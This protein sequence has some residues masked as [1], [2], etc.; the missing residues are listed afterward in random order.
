MENN[1]NTQENLQNEE[2]EVEVEVEVEPR[3]I[4]KT[5]RTLNNIRIKARMDSLAFAE[6]KGGL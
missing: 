3:I 6:Q 4:T 5:I 2:V 1:N